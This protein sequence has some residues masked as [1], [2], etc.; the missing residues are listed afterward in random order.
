MFSGQINPQ[1]TK[2]YMS[3]PNICKNS[4][5]LMIVVYTELVAIFLSIFKHGAWDFE[6]LGFY[7]LYLL[8]MSL[9][10]ASIV[11]VLS[12]RNANIKTGLLLAVASSV[13][14]V[15]I[16]TAIFL[17]GN[18]NLLF[19][20]SVN[21][22]L[23][24]LLLFAIA[25][26]VIWRIIELISV[27][28]SRNQAEAQA[29]MQA[30]QSRIQPH[31]LFNSLNTIS[32][33]TA[34][35]AKSAEQAIESL[36]MLFRAGLENDN[37]FHH[38][39]SEITFCKRYV[40]LESWRLADRL[41]ITWNINVQA[42]EQ[43]LVPKLLLQ[44]LVENAILHGQD[45]DGNVTIDIDIRES[46]SDLSLVIENSLGNSSSRTGNGIAIDNIRERLFVL[47][48][49]QYTFKTRQADHTYRVLMRFQKITQ[50]QV[51]SLQ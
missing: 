9:G 42:P 37:K 24:R 6:R 35:D 30:L 31:F 4:S 46:K 14:F 49:D 25:V 5:I 20:S 27:A 11:C 26:F 45:K 50:R 15:I 13:T 8:W 1:D 28:E 33:L 17:I 12:K 16:E 18:N 32:E 36:S 2:F 34:T 7:S 22:V 19:D 41:A 29:R 48:D 10:T 40:E 43:Y 47:F 21:A 51:Q 44:P 39:A 23:Y 38:L 3:A